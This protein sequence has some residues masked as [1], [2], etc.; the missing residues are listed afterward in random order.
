MQNTLS[1][2]TNKCKTIF[3]MVAL[4]AAQT[5]AAATFI[6]TNTDDSGPGSLRQAI[7]DSNSSLDD[8]I[9]Q[10]T[11]DIPGTGPFL[12]QPVHK[13]LPPIKQPVVIDGFSQPG[14][15][16]NTLQDGNNSILLVEINGSLITPADGQPYTYGS[17]LYFF[18]T[19]DGS[20]VEGLIIKEWHF[21]GILSTADV[22]VERNIIG[23][24]DDSARLVGDEIDN[25]TK[26]PG[27]T[28]ILYR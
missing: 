6:V 22:I 25:G 26:K 8:P 18:P 19:A 5:V 2:I 16:P 3:F 20:K 21:A 1:T 13:L 17:G 4:L 23:T 12:I 14:A 27:T 28:I 10:I 11:F 9:N 15:Q 24:S 7:I